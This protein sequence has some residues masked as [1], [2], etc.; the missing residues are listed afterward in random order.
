MVNED[1]GWHLSGPRL[2]E[3][4]PTDLFDKARQSFRKL[5]A[6]FIAIVVVILSLSAWLLFRPSTPR[7][8]VTFVRIIRTHKWLQLMEGGGILAYMQKTDFKLAYIIGSGA[9]TAR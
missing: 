8:S 5:Q 3:D 9:A 7:L 4:F 2:M 6:V 1:S